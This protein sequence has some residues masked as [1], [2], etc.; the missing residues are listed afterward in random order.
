MWRWRLGQRRCS[1]MSGTWCLGFSGRSSA[2]WMPTPAPAVPVW[3][4]TQRELGRRASGPGLLDRVMADGLDAV[5]DPSDPPD[6]SGYLHAAVAGGLPQ[7]VLS[8]DPAFCSRHSASWTW[9][10]L[11]RPIGSSA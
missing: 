8:P 11:G 9:S 7:A 2:P 5:V 6:L 1:S 3:P 4:L 10:R